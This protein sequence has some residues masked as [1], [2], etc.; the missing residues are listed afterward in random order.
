MLQL[1]TIE[2]LK[3]VGGVIIL[4]LALSL[5]AATSI[6]VH[7]HLLRNIFFR[8][9]LAKGTLLCSNSR[10]FREISDLGESLCWV[11]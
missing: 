9:S 6:T 8:S 5:T 4:S 1:M 11:G 10:G 2:P 3:L 7:I